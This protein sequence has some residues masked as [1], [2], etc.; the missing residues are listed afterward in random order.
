MGDVFIGRQKELN[1]LRDL[2]AKQS[3][4]LVVIYGRRRVGKSRLA[5]EFGKDC[6]FY[7]FEGLYPGKGT[8]N[9]DQLQAFHQRFE[10]YFQDTKHRFFAD[11]LEAFHALS[12]KT[13]TGKVVVLLDEISW[14]GQYDANFLGKLKNAWDMD[15]KQNP[16]L[17]LILCGSVS[18]WVE[19]NLLRHEGF[20][21][22]ISV[23]LRLQEQPLADCN[24]YWTDKDSHISDY[25]KFKMLAVTGGTPKYLEEINPKLPA[26]EN[27]QKLC[28]MPSGLL[29]NDYDYIFSSMLE[30]DSEVYHKIILTLCQHN[31]LRNEI[32]DKLDKS[33][34]GLLTSYL[35]ELYVSGFITRDFTWNLRT[36]NFAKLSQYRLSDNYIRFYTKYIRP[37]VPKIK[38]TPFSLSSLSA[39]PN[40]SGIMGLQVENLM[41][42]NRQAILAL[43]NIYP[44]EVICDGPFFQR[45]T[46]K[47]K[48]CQIDY[49]VQTRQGVLYLCEIKFTRTI[50]TTKVIDD[51]AEKLSR[52]AKPK[53][54]SIVPILFYIGDIQDAVLDSQFFGKIIDIRRLLARF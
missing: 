23:K 6:N 7:F 4:S 45:K 47:A 1:L 38:H 28:F 17:V 32:L 39:L 10:A 8:T 41:L 24:Q 54:M 2:W 27:I 30:R 44:D 18:H 52:I 40:W 15:F 36:G 25:E 33:S 16:N 3:A 48:G 29:F 21:G 37:I 51:V 31:L 26:E 35:D 53:N 22:R 49:L 20:Y 12:S 42:N 5:Q 14:M 43:M 13:Q 46:T 19:Q 9:G 50:I 34:G 11:W